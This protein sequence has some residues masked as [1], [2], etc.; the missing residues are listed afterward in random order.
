MIILHYIVPILTTEVSTA[1]YSR[2]I[3]FRVLCTNLAMLT[4]YSDIK[5]RSHQ[6]FYIP[7]LSN[8][9]DDLSQLKGT[10]YIQTPRALKF[11]TV[12]VYPKA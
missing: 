11:V 6:F 8:F 10:S 7:L 5:F 3:M 4:V 2:D 12:S 1:E 9:T